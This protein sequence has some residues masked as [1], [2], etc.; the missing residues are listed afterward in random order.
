[1]ASP[2]LALDR[3]PQRNGG[4]N[5]EWVKQLLAAAAIALTTWLLTTT[6]MD[7][8]QENRITTVEKNVD[9]KASKESLDGVEKR[10]DRIEG[11]LDKVLDR[12]AR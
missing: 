3:T 6:R 12:R 4:G 2:G 1:M 7:A 9:G 8:V 5:Y 10:L 11:K